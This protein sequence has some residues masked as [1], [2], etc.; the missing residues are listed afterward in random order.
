MIKRLLLGLLSVLAIV[1]IV[2]I[3][4]YTCMSREMVFAGDPNYSHKVSNERI[5]YEYTK[6]KEYGYVDYI[7]YA[8]YLLELRKNGEIDEETRVKAVAIA[9][10]EKDA[11]GNDNDSEIVIKYKNKFREYYE[12][13]GY[14]VQRVDAKMQTST[15]PV[16]GGKQ[17][18][19]QG[20]NTFGEIDRVQITLDRGYEYELK[21]P[22]KE[23]FFI[24]TGVDSRIPTGLASVE[25][26]TLYDGEGQDIT[27][28]FFMS[29]GGIQ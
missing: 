9:F 14:T 10:K 20:R 29:M 12:S 22:R 27:E 4:I 26:I 28:S 2:M 18:L 8:D 21:L 3:L 25:Q 15:K 23:V 16:L 11:N 7:T 6:W 1:V 13:K 24:H 19:F 17:L 5:A